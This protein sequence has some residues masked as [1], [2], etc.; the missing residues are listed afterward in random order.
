MIATDPETDPGPGLIRGT[1]RSPEKP[2]PPSQRFWIT[3]GYRRRRVQDHAARISAEAA[4]VDEFAGKLAAIESCMPKAQREA[5]RLALLSERAAKL[6][7]FHELEPTHH[8]VK[9]EVVSCISLRAG[10]SGL[11]PRAF[12]LC[13][14]SNFPNAPRSVVGLLLGAGALALSQCRNPAQERGRHAYHG[15][16]EIECSPDRLV[17]SPFMVGTLASSSGRR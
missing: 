6:R 2:K 15:T 3:R 5:A 4:I 11:R 17:R 7:R 8:A 1:S 13:V 10:T 9:I 16:T 12:P 14:P